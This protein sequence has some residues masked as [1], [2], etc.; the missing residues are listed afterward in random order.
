[1][2]ESKEEDFLQEDG[3]TREGPE[4]SP[5]ILPEDMFFQR[6]A[7]ETGDIWDTASENESCLVLDESDT[8]LEVQEDFENHNVPQKTVGN[9]LDK[10][11][12][13]SIA[14]LSASPAFAESGTEILGVLTIFSVFPRLKRTM[15]ES[16]EEDFLQEGREARERLEASPGILPKDMFFQKT[17]DETGDV[18]DTAPENET[19]EVLEESDVSLGMEENFENHDVP[20]KQLGNQLDK[21]SSKSITYHNDERTM[22]GI[23]EED[24][25][26]EGSEPEEMLEASPGRLPEDMFFQSTAEETGDTWDTD[27]E[28]ET[29]QVCEGSEMILEAQENFENHDVPK[30]EDGN[31]LDKGHST[32]IPYLSD[33]RTMSDMKEENFL[34]E[35]PEPQEM[36]E[37]SPGRLPKD[38]FFQT[39]ADKSRVW[40]AQ[41]ENQAHQVLEER[42]TNIEVKEN[43]GNQEESQMGRR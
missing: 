31:Q 23:K 22:T 21:G 36:L 42:D 26:Q 10:G 24:F 13:E 33:E 39:T 4:A 19:C 11:N 14:Y 2:T 34:Q 32:S 35:G 37:G 5:E 30:K 38:V 28:N 3:E 41:S 9:Q 15:T 12:S 25:L 43:I 18:W 16:K 27:S 8:T 20:K 17:V 40:D 1:M 6:T 7:D 29:C